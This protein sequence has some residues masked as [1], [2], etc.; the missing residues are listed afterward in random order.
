MANEKRRRSAN[1]LASEKAL[2]VDL[3]TDHFDIIEN[4]RTDGVSMRQ[5]LGE[6]STISS[7][8]NAQTIHSHRTADNLKAQWESL[9]KATKKEASL[10][11]MHLIQTGGGP[12]SLT[13]VIED[14]LQLKILSLITPSA[15]GL[16]NPIDS[17]NITSVT[18]KSFDWGDYTPK[19]LKTPISKPLRSAEGNRG[20]NS[21]RRLEWMSKR[22][23]QL[24]NSSLETLQQLKANAITTQMEHTVKERQEAKELFDIQMDIQRE[25]LKQEKIKTRLLLLELRRNKKE[26]YL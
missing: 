10:R 17:D 13:S 22:R 25:I 23:P 15:V 11:R 1:W 3:V 6:W 24:S 2:L 7:K 19:N 8:Y 5:K 12:E 9:K 18:S 16:H 21:G 20:S 4:K 14:P 26:T